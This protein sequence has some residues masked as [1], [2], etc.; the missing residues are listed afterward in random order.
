[1]QKT[2]WAT[3][4]VGVLSTVVLVYLAGRYGVPILAPFLLAC[5]V[6]LFVR[7]WGKR[8][9]KWT[10]VRPGICSV[11]VL[12]ALLLVLGCGLYLGGYYLWR[13]ADLFYAWLTQN[14]NSL[15]GALSG[16]F[17]TKG[18]GSVLPAFLQELLELPL[19]SDLFGGLDQL[20]QTL[21]ESL[22]A[23]L[24]EALTGAA[25]DAAT[26][27]PSMALS[28]LVFGFSCFYLALDGDRM[29][30]WVLG[31]AGDGHRERVRRIL[32][33]VADALRGYLRAYGLIFCLTFAELLIG[34]LLIGVRY[35]FLLA[36]LIALVDLLPVLGSGAVLVPWSIVSLLSGNVRVGAGLLI[37]F[38]VITLVRQIAEPKI[39]GNSLGL[40]PL[41]TLGAMYVSFCLFGAIGLVLGPCAALIAKVIL[42]QSCSDI[43][44]SS[45]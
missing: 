37:L 35:S 38:G 31:C 32:G 15:A 28:V 42:Q 7:P 12:I 26:G 2:Q 23:R 39:I 18:Q 14:A 43:P 29:Y 24:G 17:A 40:H 45:E 22:L 11:A 34:F 21:I 16:L 9:S 6:V 3:V 5:V 8:L 30:E 36:M 4:A 13:E 33:S 19:L 27:L 1:M 25:V 44:T 41:V 10:A 20:A